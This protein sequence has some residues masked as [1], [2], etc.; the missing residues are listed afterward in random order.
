MK[1][2]FCVFAGAL[3]FAL[4]VSVLFAGCPAEVGERDTPW[5]LTAGNPFF[6]RHPTSRIYASAPVAFTPLEVAISER[7]RNGADVEWQWYTSTGFNN[8]LITP[9]P[10]ETYSTFVPPAAGFFVASATV[11]GRRTVSNPA[12]VR[13]GVAPQ[14][15]T[16][17]ITNTQHQYIRGFGGMSNAFWIGQGGPDN[18]PALAR[19]YMQRADIDAMFHPEG[20]L[21]FNMFR[22]HVF[23]S[24]SLTMAA[25]GGGVLPSAPMA[26]VARNSID[27]I[28]SG[29]YR[30]DWPMMAPSN[31]DF[32]NF[33][34]RVNEFG[35]YVFAAPWTP[36]FTAWKGNQHL[37]AGGPQAPGA[38]NLLPAFYRDY[39]M[40]L[41]Y[42]ALEMNRRGAPLFSISMQN[43]PTY[44]APYYGMV[45]TAQEQANWMAGYGHIVT[46]RPGGAESFPPIP[47]AGG[48]LDGQPRPGQ[49]VLLMSGTPHNLDGGQ[50][51]FH[52]AA[53]NNPD[54]RANMEIVGYHTYGH[55]GNRTIASINNAITGPNRRETWM[56]EK[57]INNTSP[58]GQYADS[59]WDMIWPVANEIHHVIAHNNTNAYI[60]WYLKRFYSFIG[61]GTF[62]TP[63]GAIL[64]RG[65]AM[66]HFSRFFTDTVRLEAAL[67]GAIAQGIG[68]NNQGHMDAG[69]VPAQ[70]AIPGVPGIRV[71]AAM[72]TSNPTTDVELG[73]GFGC[74]ELEENLGGLKRLEDMVSVLLTDDRTDAPGSSHTVRVAL[75]SG[76][77]ATNAYGII[78]ASG[79]VPHSPV[80]VT[81]NEAGT[82][83]WVTLPSN[84]LVSLRFRGQWN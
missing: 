57:N 60:W 15:G 79:L 58:A 37:Y 12:H 6:E 13:V 55:W 45:W 69:N 34:K 71:M 73:R 49:R 50:A 78:S 1:K 44:P 8:I 39:A 9:I 84:S 29:A 21:Q 63:E 31:R 36:P 23:P 27:R 83:A 54:A 11:N 20:P 26:D 76:F 47:G 32:V 25:P 62:G 28:L 64:P 67:C 17:N 43:E 66:G 41:R 80:M 3:I 52:V 40:Y 51:N 2:S 22:I 59:T 68:A 65:F 77:T 46:G 30:V 19:S 75:P 82:Y 7:S 70:Q 56:T 14:D 72:R 48:N 38:S 4:S 61:D 33:V 18:P 53:L 74:P 5:P 24:T 35:G 16:L 81:L 42:W 10:G